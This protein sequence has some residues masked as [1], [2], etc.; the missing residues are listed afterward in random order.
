MKIAKEDVPVK[1]NTP[2][3]VARQ[4]TEFGDATGYGKIS[5][6]YFT[7]KA[8]TD[9]SPLLEGLKDDKC[10]TP[11]WGFVIKGDITV[12]Y[13]NKSQETVT[14]GDLFYWPPGHTVMVNNDSDIVLFSPQKEHTEVMDH[15]LCK[16]EA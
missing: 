11:H 9:F 1:I 14:T 6:E 12:E 5:G 15:I 13:T 8:G 16:I 3:A 10:Q 7:L 2:V 4:K